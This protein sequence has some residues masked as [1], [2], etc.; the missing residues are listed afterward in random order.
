V[1]KLFSMQQFNVATRRPTTE[2]VTRSVC[3][4]FM[5]AHSETNCLVMPRFR[6]MQKIAVLVWSTVKTA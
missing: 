6:F 3:L 1:P 2:T 4:F 5:E